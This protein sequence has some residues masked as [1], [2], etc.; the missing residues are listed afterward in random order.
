[1]NRFELHQEAK[2]RVSKMEFGEPVTNV[3]AGDGNPTRQ[4]YFVSLDIKSHKNRFGI[5]HRDYTARCT[6]KRG[7]FWNTDIQVVFPGHLSLD[8]SREIYAPI[9]AAQF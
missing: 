2:K 7:K 6:D 9:H 1:M 4:G 3:C 8:E 5:T